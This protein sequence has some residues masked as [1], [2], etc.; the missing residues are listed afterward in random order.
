MATETMSQQQL[1][2]PTTSGTTPQTPAATAKDQSVRELIETARSAPAGILG[3]AA[4]SFATAG[5]LWSSF[6][7]VDFGWLAWAALVPLLLLVRIERPTRLMYPAIYL[8]GLVWSVFTLQWM[9][10]GDPSMYVALAALSV[11]VAMYFPAF[12]AVAR[13]AVHRL[14][15]P[16]L[17]AV[18]VIWVGFEYLRATLLT[19]FAWY[20]LGHTQYAFPEI[21]QVSD[22]V[23]AYGV[24]FLVALGAACLAGLIPTAWLE[25]MKLFPPVKLPDEYSH[26]SPE[27]L[28]ENRSRADFRRPWLN[29]AVTLSVVVAALVYGAVRRGQAEFV[30]G[31]RVGLVQGN[32]PTSLKHDPTEY[33]RIF[34]VHDALTGMTVQHQPDLIVWPETMFR[35]P[36]QMLDPELDEAQLQ[37]MAPPQLAGAQQYRWIESWKD[38]AVRQTLTELSQRAGAS[39]IV[40]VDTWV[41]GKDRIRAYNSAAFVT[42][43]GGLVNRYDKMH[44]VIF[45]EYVPLRDEMPWLQAFSPIPAEY[46]LEKGESAKLLKHRD[47]TVSPIICFEDTVPQLVRGIAAGADEKVDVFVNLTNDGWFAGSS[48]LDQHLITASFRCIETRTPMVRAV[49]TGCSAIID[50]DGVVRDPDVFIDADAETAEEARAFRDANSGRMTKSINAALVGNVPLDNR[51]SFYVRNGD[52]FAQ[53]CCLATVFCCIAGPFRRKRDVVR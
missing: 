13:A 25:R 18:P 12:V 11:Y 29:V 30:D 53:S 16:F 4:C 33:P 20:F 6:T 45:G 21:T 14:S 47:W 17:V 44:R 34:Q 49:N 39:M 3:G 7:P 27:G 5:L 41:A 8:G 22:L 36:L 1:P 9:R 50:G 10:L 40:G 23:G 51:T 43:Q 42:P 37:A 15:I 2:I 24:S 19:G 28:A 48:E 52:W 31:P 32:F 38:P 26:L 46:G 35:W